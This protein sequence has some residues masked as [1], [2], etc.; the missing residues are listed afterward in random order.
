MNDDRDA[1]RQ[2]AAVVRGCLIALFIAAVFWGLAG[3]V[4]W[5]VVRH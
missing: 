1:H 5:F 4:V 2:D 3:V